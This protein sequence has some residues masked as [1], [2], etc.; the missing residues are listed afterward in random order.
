MIVNRNIKETFRDIA[1]ASELNANSVD[2]SRSYIKRLLKIFNNKLTEEE[3]LLVVKFL[4][5][6][7]YYR[8]IITDPDNIIQLNN[9]RLRNVTYYILL[10][11]VSVIG[12]SAVLGVSDRLNTVIESFQH[13]FKLLSI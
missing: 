1:V 11:I 3:R 4:F 12:V 5:E 9:I 2:P 6:N 7:I 8:N 13:V 10:A